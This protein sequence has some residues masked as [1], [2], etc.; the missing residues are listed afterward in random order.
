MLFLLTMY[1]TKQIL[2]SWYRCTT[3]RMW[4]TRSL[5]S[6]KNSEMSI[7]ISFTTLPSSS[8]F[9]KKFSTSYLVVQKEMSQEEWGE[10]GDRVVH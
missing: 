2:G 4:L 1:P 8:S 9:W 5:I 3:C 6:R 7:T 10:G